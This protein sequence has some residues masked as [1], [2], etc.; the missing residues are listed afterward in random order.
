MEDK[1]IKEYQKGFNE[2]YI[3]AGSMP[4]LA[5]QLSEIKNRSP[6]I[7]GLK[8]GCHQYILD[9]AREK[10]PSFLK[11]KK[12]INSLNKKIDRDRTIDK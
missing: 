6:R 10:Y 1:E 5:T 11:P 9:K 4:E 2:G 3:I 8:D 12:N 7:D